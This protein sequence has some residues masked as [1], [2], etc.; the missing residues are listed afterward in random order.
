MLNAFS[1]HPASPSSN[2][3]IP[4]HLFSLSVL[5][6]FSSLL[7]LMTLCSAVIILKGLILFSLF[8]LLFLFSLS[9][10]GWI[11]FTFL[12][13]SYLL[14]TLLC[15]RSPLVFLSRPLPFLP[16]ICSLRFYELHIFVCHNPGCK[17]LTIFQAKSRHTSGSSAFLGTI[18]KVML[19]R[20]LLCTQTVLC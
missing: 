14:L 12:P 6:S 16:H 15:S 7:H 8:F 11:L 5:H 10:F 2:T 1:V 3:R 18:Q 19:G 9:F 17:V 4:F 13:S 20:V